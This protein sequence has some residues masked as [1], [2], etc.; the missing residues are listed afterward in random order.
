MELP[1]AVPDNEPAIAASR[2][3]SSTSTARTTN[4]SRAAAAQGGSTVNNKNNN[5]TEETIDFA[6]INV[7]DDNEVDIW[8]DGSSITD[9][10]H[11]HH[12]GRS[13]DENDAENN[14]QRP[15]LLAFLLQEQTNPS[16]QPFLTVTEQGHRS[17]TAAVTAKTRGEL[18]AA[19]DHHTEAAHC[20]H[21]AA[22]L[23]QSH[24]AALAK[25]LLLLSQTQANA[26]KALQRIIHLPPLRRVALYR[27]Q[28]A[29]LSASTFLGTTAQQRSPPTPSAPPSLSPPPHSSTGPPAVPPNAIDE[30]ME[31]ERELRSMDMKLDLNNSI[32]S[33]DARNR[34]KSSMMGDSYMVVPPLTTTG[35][36][37]LASSF[38]STGRNGPIVGASR[39]RRRPPNHDRRRQRPRR[40]PRPLSRLTWKVLGGVTL[41]KSWLRNLNSNNNNKPHHHR[42]PL[43]SKLCASWNPSGPW[44]M[45]MRLC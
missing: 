20:F 36:Q 16:H 35:Q 14:E 7:G 32:A 28:E 11:H 13:D 31:L 9:H 3:Y 15:D 42:R 17:R 37:G 21:Q 19:L 27:K 43:P 1:F 6:Y 8:L 30:M 38:L 29:D 39:R 12:Y 23:V 24:D 4:T 40:R 18:K 26:A 22:S 34:M 44:A 41:R 45:K 33:L 25:S 10:H 5:E 2:S